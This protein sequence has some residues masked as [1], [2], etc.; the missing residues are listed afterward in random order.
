MM[1]GAGINACEKHRN[2]LRFLCM[3]Y[4]TMVLVALFPELERHGVDPDEFIEVLRM[5]LSIEEWFHSTNLITKVRTARP[6]TD[7]VIEM[8]QQVFPRPEGNG[9]DLPKNHGLTKM[10]WFMCKYGSD[11]NY[12]GG[13]VECNHK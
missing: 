1:Q 4:T 6:L 9:W 10:Q 2:L 3:A 13:R 8:I 12:Y 5:Y 11:I 7:S